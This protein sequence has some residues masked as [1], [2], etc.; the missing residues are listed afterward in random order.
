V[1]HCFLAPTPACAPRPRD[2]W[3]RRYDRCVNAG[4]TTA[5]IQRYLT[6]LGRP[7]GG[8]PTE[9][10]VRDVLAAAAARLQLL[11]SAMLYRSYPRLTHPPL[12]LEVDEMLG[13]VV[14]RLM[15]AMQKVRPSTVRQFFALANQHMR[16][17]LNDLARRLDDQ[18]PTIGLDEERLRAPESSGSGLSINTRVMLDAIEKL[19]EDEREAFDLV[20]IQGLAHV[21]AAEIL[22]VSAKTIQ[23]RLNRALLV[24]TEQFRSLLPGHARREGSGQS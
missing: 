17:E 21:E 7:D 18:P 16:W 19:P 12:N 13:A 1:I 23:R 24:L 8:P 6:E 2:A 4:E 5:A 20:R 14:E 11:C 10:A 9:A 22:D 3:T 15:Q